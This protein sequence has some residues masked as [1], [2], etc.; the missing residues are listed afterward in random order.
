[1]LQT[2]TFMT[3]YTYIHTSAFQSIHKCATSTEYKTCQTTITRQTQT[4][5]AESSVMFLLG[6]VNLKSK[7]KSLNKR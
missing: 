7:Q 6:A 5:I 3:V 2:A 1:M 4:E